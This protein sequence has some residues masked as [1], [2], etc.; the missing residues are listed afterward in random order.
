MKLADMETKVIA[1]A[2]GAGAGVIV[3]EFVDWTLGV[4]VWHQSTAA[5]A[6][7]DAIKAVPAPVA[8]LVGLALSVLGAALAGWKAAHTS[9]P[10]TDAITISQTIHNPAIE[11]PQVAPVADVGHLAI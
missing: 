6:S 10:D 4:T 3:G 2:S 11:Q 8:A 9:R 5:S 7:A 1:A